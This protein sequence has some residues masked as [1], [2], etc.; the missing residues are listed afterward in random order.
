M[1]RLDRLLLRRAALWGA[2]AL[3]V[4]PAVGLRVL[5]AVA[6]LTA[7]R[8]RLIQTTTAPQACQAGRRCH[9]PKQEQ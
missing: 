7:R 6:T 1:S 8:F 9:Q 2:V 3:L 4:W 5:T